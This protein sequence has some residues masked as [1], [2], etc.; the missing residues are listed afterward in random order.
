MVVPNS[1]VHNDMKCQHT[2]Y[3]TT[4]EKELDLL[5]NIRAMIIVKWKDDQHRIAEPVII[6]ANNWAIECDSWAMT[7]FEYTTLWFAIT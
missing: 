2:C 1:I 7:I 3:V 6:H 5:Y 4:N